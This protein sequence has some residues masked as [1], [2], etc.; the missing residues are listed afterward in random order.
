MGIISIEKADRLFWLGRYTERVFTTLDAFFKYFDKMLDE[1]NSAYIPYCEKLAIPMIYSDMDDFIDNYLFSKDDPNSVISNLIRAYDNGIVLRDELSSISLSYI[2]LS[3]NIM[4]NCV[5]DQG[6]TY[7]LQPVKDYIYA[8]WG[9]LDDR[10]EDE[11]GRNIIK[12][13]RYLERV[14][15]YM[16]LGY[17]IR[18]IQKEYRK[19]LNRL[20]RVRIGYNLSEVD[21]LG[22]II[23]LGEGWE[24]RKQDAL[25][26]LWNIL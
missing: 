6:L 1:D 13:G 24:A 25:N 8:F 14:D 3:L 22:E 12:C 5:K 9:C 23:G 18:S 16:R 7:Q 4:E 11:E 15:L 19:F 10:V 26:A 20:Q 21:K 17:N 2:Q